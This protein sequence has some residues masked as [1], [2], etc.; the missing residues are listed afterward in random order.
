MSTELGNGFRGNIN[1]KDGESITQV[2]QE[3]YERQV[4]EIIKCKKDPIYFADNYFYIVSPA[5]GKHVIETYPKQKEM[6]KLMIE[7]TRTVSVA[8][9]QVGKCCQ[10]DSMVKSI[11]EKN[12]VGIKKLI[13]CIIL[14]VLKL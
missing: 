11:S 2:T 7:K 6:I 4:S 13:Y 10:R 8:S 9:R 5:R 3:E 1:V 12:I 14:K